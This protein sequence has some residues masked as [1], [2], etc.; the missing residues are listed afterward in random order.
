MDKIKTESIKLSKYNPRK[1]NDDDLKR[2]DIK[3]SRSSNR[4]T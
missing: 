1:I 3:G 2:V 4:T